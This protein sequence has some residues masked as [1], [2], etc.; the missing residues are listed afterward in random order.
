MGASAKQ[1]RKRGRPW[2]R[3]G[4]SEL[5][6][7]PS[8]QTAVASMKC[9]LIRPPDLRHRSVAEATSLTCSPLPNLPRAATTAQQTRSL[10]SPTHD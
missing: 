1:Q 9:G 3:N 5:P 7:L 8:M 10:V 2:G 6:R 4:V